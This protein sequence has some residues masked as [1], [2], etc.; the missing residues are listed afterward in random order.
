MIGDH[1]TLVFWDQDQFE[2][3]IPNLK[4]TKIDKGTSQ[5]ASV[6]ANEHSVLS[7]TPG[8]SISRTDKDGNADKV[9]LSDAE[10]SDDVE[11]PPE[12]V[13][14]PIR[15]NNENY[16]KK[17]ELKRN[18]KPKMK[19]KLSMIK[20]EKVESKVVKK[21]APAATSSKGKGKKKP[22]KNT[23]LNV[24]EPLKTRRP[25]KAQGTTVMSTADSAETPRSTNEK[26]M[27]S[28]DKNGGDSDITESSEEEEDIEPQ[29]SGEA[30]TVAAQ[31]NPC[32]WKRE[33]VTIDMREMSLRR[34]G[35]VYHP[36][37]IVL[38]DPAAVLMSY[39]PMDYI[40]EVVLPLSN[41]R[42]KTGPHGMR[43]WEDI[44]LEELMT[45]LGLIISMECYFIPDRKLYWKSEASHDLF[46]AMNFGRF[47]SWNRFHDIMWSLTLSNSSDEFD[48]VRD[49]VAEVNTILLKTLTTGEHLCL[50]ESM[51]KAFH[52]KLR[53]KVKIKRKPRPIGTEIKAVCDARTKIVV[54][55][56][57]NE[58]K[59]IM[60]SKEFFHEHGASIATTLRLLKPFFGSGKTLVADSWFGSVRNAVELMQKGIYSIMVVK[61]AHKFYPEE[62]KALHLSER[63]SG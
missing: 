26:G 63:G 16:G 43:Q 32:D 38:A 3:E 59:E 31:P 51:V 54:Q 47:M 33:E 39:L 29:T 15:V 28:R 6:N 18:I 9:I 7:E 2:A 50:D 22:V 13:V 36:D 37:P 1:T 24:D 12:K 56:E 60:H 30:P 20:K 34:R 42:G 5:P 40:K 27:S 21:L 4:L 14:S 62:L 44:T 46:P 10:L 49:F 53:G 41:V 11:N 23:A 25:R 35:A 48:Q 8:P 55:M 57:I 58:G 19:R 52:K 17:T 61:T 45:F